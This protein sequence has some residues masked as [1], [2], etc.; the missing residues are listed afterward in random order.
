MVVISGAEELPVK[1]RSEV[2]TLLKRGAE[3]RTTAATRMN[4]NSSRSHSIFTVSVVIRENTS[5]GE[6]LVKQG[7]L[8][9]VDLA[10][11][12]HIGRSGAEGKR[13]KEAGEHFYFGVRSKS[14]IYKKSSRV[15]SK[16]VQRKALL[17][18]YNEEIEKLRRDLRTAREKNGIFLSQESYEGMEH[19]I[20]EKTEQLRELEG[21]LDAAIGKLQKFIEDQELMDEQYRELYHRNKRLE[22][23]LR[24]RVDE[25]DSTKKARDMVF[26]QQLDLEDWWAKE[27][28]LSQLIVQNKQVVVAARAKM[29]AEVTACCS[30]ISA[31]I[32]NGA[33]KREA[34]NKAVGAF[35]HLA[36]C[37]T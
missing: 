34:I 2:Y 27:E 16:A 12:E 5:N 18:E 10:G 19:E 13:A 6:E 9:L 33:A 15:Q 30:A 23:K 4:M 8:N 21:Q 26:D 3:Q 32:E 24:Q 29:L 17:K 28:R 35:L 7:K 1:D 20:A 11:S 37:A 31:F 22:A 36:C 25:L 14:Q